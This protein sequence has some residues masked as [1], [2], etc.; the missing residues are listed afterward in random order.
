MNPLKPETVKAIRNDPFATLAL[1][2]TRDFLYLAHRDFSRLT[3]SGKMI[4]E[5]DE[6]GI[7]WAALGE[8]LGTG[9]DD[10]PSDTTISVNGVC[11][12]IDAIHALQKAIQKN[13]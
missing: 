13:H 6:A 9:P 5:H 11:M 10:L 8:L 1:K 7:A 3:K 4:F 2:A 12:N